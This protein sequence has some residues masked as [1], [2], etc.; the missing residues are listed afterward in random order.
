MTLLHI[1]LLFAFGKLGHAISSDMQLAILANIPAMK[2]NASYPVQRALDERTDLQIRDQC[3]ANSSPDCGYCSSQSTKLFYQ[4]HL[5][6]TQTMAYGAL[7]T[8]NAVPPSAPPVTA[9]A[10][11]RVNV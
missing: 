1:V 5:I 4:N 7:L 11:A 9:S 10:V 6:P 2:S 3:A 8:V